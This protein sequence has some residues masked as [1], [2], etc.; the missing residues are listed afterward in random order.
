M[1]K[2]TEKIWNKQTITQKIDLLRGIS[3]YYSIIVRFI[4]TFAHKWRKA[5]EV[6]RE[7]ISTS[8]KVPNNQTDFGQMT[9]WNLAK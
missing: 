4:S 2:N 3:I 1:R 5:I 8:L 6:Q 9:K 7:D